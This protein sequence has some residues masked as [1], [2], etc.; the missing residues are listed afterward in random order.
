MDIDAELDPASLEGLPAQRPL[1]AVAI[2]AVV[3]TVVYTAIQLVMEGGVDVIETAAFVIVF[4]G[5]YV[6]FLYLRRQYLSG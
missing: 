2:A 6:A 4:A 5:V 3:A 1:L